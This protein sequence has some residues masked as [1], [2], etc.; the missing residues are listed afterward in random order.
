MHYHNA[1]IGNKYNNTQQWISN[2]NW[3]EKLCMYIPI[4]ICFEI[5]KHIKLYRFT[6]GRELRVSSPT[7]Y[8]FDSLNDDQ[9]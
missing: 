4:Q 6:I 9:I 5:L 2:L 3:N 7:W 1:L 8:S